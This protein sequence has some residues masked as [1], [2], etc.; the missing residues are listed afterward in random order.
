MARAHAPV[1]FPATF[2]ARYR[3]ASRNTETSPPR[4]E[5]AGSRLRIAVERARRQNASRDGWN[6]RLV[7]RA[8]QPFKTRSIIQSIVQANERQ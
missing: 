2:H 6:F 5:V 8:C 1:S 3:P 7:F 4:A